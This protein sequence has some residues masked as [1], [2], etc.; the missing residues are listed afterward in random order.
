MALKLN[1][2]ETKTKQDTLVEQKLT[3]SLAEYL[4]P[5]TKFSIG[6]AY[7]E[8]TIPSDLGE[9]NGMTLQFS[10]GNRM[11]FADK[12]NV[13]SLLYPNPSDG[14]AY[15]LPF[16]PCRSFHELENV[17][18]LVVDDVTGENGDVI[19]NNDA[20][21]LVGDCKGLIDRN[22]VVSNNIGVRA[23]QFRLGI[24]PQTE[25]TVMRIA[26]G[27]LAPT[28]LDEFGGS[29]FRMGGNV[30]DG[31]LRSRFGYDLVL[32]T[33][34]FKGRKGEDAI[35]PG[36]YL[37]SIGLGVKS[38]AFYREHSLGTQVLVNYPQ[39]VKE[40][41][42]PIIKQQAEKLAQE[43][44]D[45]RKLAQRS[46]GTYERRKAIL[47]Q[48]QEIEPDIQEAIQ[49]FSLFDSLDSG[50]DAEE[51][52]EGENFTTQQQKDLFLYSL[53]KA[54]LAGFNQI[55][56][57]PK[58]IAELQ[59]FVRKE[60]VEIATGRSI[61]FTSGLAQPSLE[62]QHSEISIPFLEEGQE[63]IVTRSPL[64]NSNGVITLKNKHLPEMLD[65]CVYIHP[66]T[67]MDNMQCDFDGDLL[68]FAPSKEFPKLAAEV[69][70]R[71]LP[72]NRYP[73]IVKKAKVPYQGTFAEIAVSAMEN[74]IGII[75]NEIQ[76]NV[77]LQCE[78]CAMPQAEK[79]NY[80]QKISAHFSVLV[81]RYEQGKLQIPGKILQQIYPIASLGNNYQVEQKLQLVKNLF[82]DCVAELG[83]E[84]QVAADGAKSALR[85]DDAIIR[86]CQAITAYKDVEW[87]ADKKNQEVFTNRGM[88]TNGYSP[89][90]LMIRQTNQIFQENQLVARPIEQFRKLY[91]GVEF[92]DEQKEK[93]Q[94]IKTEY[95][96]Q[97][98]GRIELEEKQKMEFSPY[99]VI[100]SPSTGKQLE[101]TNL[102]RFNAAKNSDFWQASEL[103]IQVGVRIPT[104][105]MP[106]TLFAQGK[107]MA[108]DGK[109][110]NVPIGTISTKSMKE[111]DIQPGMSIQQGKVEFHFGVSDGMVDALKQQTREYIESI[112]EEIPENQRLQMAAAIYDVSHTESSRNYSGL[113]KA[114]VA[115]SVFGEY[116][117]AQLKKLQFTEMRIVGT[118]FNECAGRDF[119]GD[120]VAVKFEDGINPREPSKI[121]RWVTVE[122]KKLGV[123]DAR[124]PHLLPGCEAI[125]CITSSPITSVIITS[126]KNPENKLQI[127]RINQY[128]FANHNWQ[129]EKANITLDMQQT[130]SRKAP[131]VFAKIGNQVLGVLNRESV[132]FLQ[133]Q[134]ASKGRTIQG[135]T[136]AGTV[137]KAPPSYAD[138]VIDPNSVKFSEIQL[139]NQNQSIST[140]AII[141][142]VVEP[143]FQGKTDQVLGNMF[144][145]AVKR[146]VESGFNR[147]QF[148]DVSPNPTPQIAAT[149]KEIAGEHKD[150]RVEFIGKTSLESGMKLLTQP[151]D[152]VL[153]VKTAETIAVIEFAASRGN[154]VATYVPETGG[155]ERQNLPSTQKT[156]RNLQVER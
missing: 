41:I 52:Q 55:L 124:S 14:A 39:A 72:E 63:V 9:Y 117:I 65:G 122:G 126:L 1:H 112:R 43:Q 81:K 87:L 125:A 145:R 97:V 5:N 57:H 7:P 35:K 13:R 116:A 45:I 67:A 50:G 136:I 105:K 61:K 135:L 42:L 139:E 142:G 140:V 138:I 4:F 84:L 8:A 120:K 70:E 149:L 95:N 53:L 89:I 59:N 33:S 21:R 47:A 137:N 30:K 143:K 69:K 119:V 86:Y 37:L 32:A 107:F 109:E 128:A 130:G 101:V 56:E 78:L 19:A 23:F 18:I 156:N 104:E 38:L 155:F 99:L 74:K 12:P 148:V 141:T 31:N 132:G 29:S 133:Q 114:G 79:F 22:F 115:F 98:R 3:N 153:G 73:D 24:K 46:I 27:T 10:S 90:D 54:D 111:Y 15:P 6:I 2:F 121:A 34:S 152:I 66:K 36:E 147:V 154:A 134:L 44:K 80:L 75:A 91:S 102:I 92:T 68:A 26:K 11:F 151:S 103:S 40:E 17:R 106:H 108:S 83:N 51:N 71:N 93:A 82:K 146:A 25:S 16:T 49:Q 118:Q 129:G 20:K 85:P 77:A 28:Q 88:K 113:K 127:D 62:L 48:S 94:Q 60:W 123:I 100:T 96:S 64:I 144:K 131:V 76:K 110:V 150:I 58:I